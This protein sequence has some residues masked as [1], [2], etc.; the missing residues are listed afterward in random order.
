MPATRS[1]PWVASLPP[2]AP[3]TVSPTPGAVGRADHRYHIGAPTRSL[4]EL[5]VLDHAGEYGVVGLRQRAGVD[6][7]LGVVLDHQL[8]GLGGGPVDDQLDDAKRH[9][10]TT[11]DSRRGDDAP[12]EVLDDA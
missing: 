1:Q 6:W 9:V 7:W 4:A 5:G 2:C 3:R 10:D 11:R 12:V 8:R